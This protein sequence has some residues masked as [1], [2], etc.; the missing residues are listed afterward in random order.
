MCTCTDVHYNFI[1][2]G[3]TVI[4]SWY[5]N[6]YYESSHSPYLIKYINCCE[7]DNSI[8]DCD[9]HYLKTTDTVSRSQALALRC[10]DGEVIIIT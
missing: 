9:M 1:L 4:S 10:I 8:K 3:A 2:I 6:N 7:K 5:A